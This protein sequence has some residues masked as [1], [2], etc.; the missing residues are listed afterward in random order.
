VRYDPNNGVVGF[1]SYAAGI[2]YPMTL[3]CQGNPCDGYWGGIV[4]AL[5]DIATNGSTRYSGAVA[6]LATHLQGPALLT[7]FVSYCL[8]G[9]RTSCSSP[10][11]PILTDQGPLRIF[12]TGSN[13][14]SGVFTAN[15]SEA[16]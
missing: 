3:N 13:V 4:G 16:D 8:S 2:M 7:G 12:A 10:A 6:G 1:G 15:I 14:G 5:S 11:T 9:S